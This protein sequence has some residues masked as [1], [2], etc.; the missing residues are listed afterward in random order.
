[1]KIKKFT[2]VL[3]LLF[4]IMGIVFFSCAST[5]TRLIR[6][7]PDLTNEN[8]AT[9]ILD[10]DVDYFWLDTR[11]SFSLK[12]TEFN[13][14]SVDWDGD[15]TVLIPEGDHVFDVFMTYIDTYN[16]NMRSWAG[17]DKIT[18]SVQKGESYLLDLEPAVLDGGS[19]VLAG[20][21]KVTLYSR[22][23]DGAGVVT[24]RNEYILERFR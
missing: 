2:S 3:V 24:F 16:G 13:G 7:S 14:E 5:S 18:I 4:V 15:L 17:T 1:M 23:H 11:P 10:G 20:S 8:S 22:Y 12:I 19:V 6:Y 9:L 21:L